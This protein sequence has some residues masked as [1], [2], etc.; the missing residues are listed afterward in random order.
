MSYVL[1]VYAALGVY[2]TL[3]GTNHPMI[4]QVDVHCAGTM[5]YVATRDT[6]LMI[7][8]VSSPAAPTLVGTFDTRGAGVYAV[9]QVVYV[10]HVSLGLQ[11]LDAQNPSRPI[12][13]GTY[14]FSNGGGIHVIG[15][16]AY[17]AGWAAGLIILDV[18]SPSSITQLG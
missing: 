11:V 2:P 3:L 10:V 12:L 7:F 5:A 8:D 18:S 9:G 4:N 1:L 13:L 17:I 6:G 14:R 15:N 16:T